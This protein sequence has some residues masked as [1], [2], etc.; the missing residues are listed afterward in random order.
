MLSR[1]AYALQAD[2]RRALTHQPL[3]GYLADWH[4]GVAVQGYLAHEK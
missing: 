4:F 2:V 3:Q 1:S